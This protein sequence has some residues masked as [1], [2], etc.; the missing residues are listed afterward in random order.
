MRKHWCF[1]PTLKM[2]ALSLWISTWKWVSSPQWRRPSA[3]R[4]PGWS[5][6]VFGT[7]KPL[8]ALSFKANVPLMKATA[9]W[10]PSLEVWT[11]LNSHSQKIIKR[12]KQKDSWPQQTPKK[13]TIQHTA[14]QSD[15]PMAKRYWLDWRLMWRVSHSLHTRSLGLYDRLCL[16]VLYQYREDKSYGVGGTFEDCMCPSPL[17]VCQLT[18]P[19]N[20]PNAGK[21]QFGYDLWSPKLL[22]TCDVQSIVVS[23][24]YL[25]HQTVICSQQQLCLAFHWEVHLRVYAILC[26]DSLSRPNSS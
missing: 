6:V 22:T 16:S 4:F 17:S 21:L 19:R 7:T 18:A 3:N 15:I 25:W 12:I 20:E 24:F 8:R 5:R 10:T 26:E 23:Y 2:T 14:V 9:S 1:Q 13:I 11:C